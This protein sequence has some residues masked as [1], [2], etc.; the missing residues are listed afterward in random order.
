MTVHSSLH[1]RACSVNKQASGRKIVLSPTSTCIKRR[2]GC[3]EWRGELSNGCRNLFN[4]VYHNLSRVTKQCLKIL[5]MKVV[6]MGQLTRKKL[7]GYWRIE[8][9]R[10]CA[11]LR[12]MIITTRKHFYRLWKVKGTTNQHSNTSISPLRVKMEGK[13]SMLW[14]IRIFLRSQRCWS[15]T[16]RIL[17]VT[18]SRVLERL[19]KVQKE[20]WTPRKLFTIWP[21][22]ALIYQ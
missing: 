20:M 16:R 3:Q 17:S 8:G 18:D 12:G 14:Q 13:I 4:S 11:T 10:I 5:N 6:I 21:Y 1:A 22:S 7:R 9:L 19:L 2:N 15:F